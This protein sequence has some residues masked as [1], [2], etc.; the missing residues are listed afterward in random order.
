M[1]QPIAPPQPQPYYYQ[2]PQHQPQPYYYQPQPGY[3]Y[4][5]QPGYFNPTHGYYNAPQP[6]PPQPNG[7]KEYPQL[8]ADDIKGTV[9]GQAKGTL[10]ATLL[11]ADGTPIK[12]AP[13]TFSMAGG[14]RVMGTV[15]TGAD[16]VAMLNSGSNILDP[17]LWAQGLG[18]GYTA[19]FAGNKQYMPATASASI[20]PAIA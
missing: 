8:T 10:R 1:T 19:H 20:N 16:G 12:G 2:P 13:I 17:I 5:P 6:Y 18:S 15:A 3:Y 11:D 7:E 4:Q 9:G 14:G